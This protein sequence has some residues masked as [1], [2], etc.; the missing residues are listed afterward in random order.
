MQ[1]SSKQAQQFFE[2]IKEGCQQLA[3]LCQLCET[4]KSAIESHDLEAFKTLL[5]EKQQQLELIGQ[6]IE[7]RNQVLE[8]LGF[9]ADEQGLQ[10]F[11][12]SLPEQQAKLIR[13]HWSKLEAQLA[14]SIELNQRNELIVKR[15]QKN[16]SQLL[17][18]M[19]GH[20]PK[21]TL[22]DQKGSAGNYSA[23]NRLGKA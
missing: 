5:L 12:S 20:S 19:Q 4:E 16:V 11:I 13:E 23:Q 22:Y 14:Q 7:Q 15:G 17:A 1:A 2:L 8:S 9:A 3:A 6:N 21:T 10:N 18:L